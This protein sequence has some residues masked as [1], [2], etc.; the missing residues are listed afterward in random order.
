MGKE[1]MGTLRT[2]FII[3]SKGKIAKIYEGVKPADHIDQVLADLSILQKKV[4]E[5]QL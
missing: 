4:F 5:K 1:Y 3:D 2:S